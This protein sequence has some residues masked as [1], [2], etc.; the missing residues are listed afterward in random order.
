ML[1]VALVRFDSDEKSEKQ[2][3]K[4]ERAKE[5]AQSFL[6][7][8]MRQAAGSGARGPSRGDRAGRYRGGGGGQGRGSGGGGSGDDPLDPSFLNEL[9]DFLIYCRGAGSP[10]ELDGWLRRERSAVSFEM[11][12]RCSE[13]QMGQMRENSRFDDELLG[14]LE[15]LMPAPRATR[16]SLGGIQVKRSDAADCVTLAVNV[17]VGGAEDLTEDLNALI[18]AVSKDLRGNAFHE[19]QNLLSIAPGLKVEKLAEPE[20]E[21]RDHAPEDPLSSHSDDAEPADDASRW[22]R[23]ANKLLAWE[24]DFMLP[25]SK[26]NSVDE[27]P[28]WKWGRNRI[29]RCNGCAK[30]LQGHCFLYTEKLERAT[31]WYRDEQ[32]PHRSDGTIGASSSVDADA[33]FDKEVLLNCARDHWSS[34]FGP[35]QDLMEQECA[36]DVHFTRDALPSNIPT[37]LIDANTGRLNRLAYATAALLNDVRRDRQRTLPP[38]GTLPLQLSERVPPF[39]FDYRCNF[40]GTK[41][42]NYCLGCRVSGCKWYIGVSNDEPRR[43]RQH[44]GEELDGG[45]YIGA[46]YIGYLTRLNSSQVCPKPDAFGGWR[47]T[48]NPEKPEEAHSVC[49]RGSY[50]AVDEDANT[51]NIAFKHGLHHVRGGVHVL[52]ELSGAE[53]ITLQREYRAQCDLCILCGRSGHKAATCTQFRGQSVSEDAALMDFVRLRGDDPTFRADDRAQGVHADVARRVASGVCS[54]CHV[55]RLVAV[56]FPMTTEDMDDMRHDDQNE[57]QNGEI[58]A[59]QARETYEHLVRELYGRRVD[60]SMLRKLQCECLEHVV[61]LGRPDIVLTAPTSYGKTLMY[62]VAAVHEVVYGEGKAVIFLPFSALMSELAHT[63]AELTDDQYSPVYRKKGRVITHEADPRVVGTSLPYGGRLRIRL[64]K[65]QG[66]REIS[67]TIWRGVSGDPIMRQHLR[68]GVFRHADIILATPD[69]WMWPDSFRANGC[70]SF[71]SMLPPHALTA[72]GAL[73]PGQAEHAQAQTKREWLRKLGLIIAD[74]AHELQ[75]VL[76]GSMSELIRRMRTLRGLLPR[77]GE[78]GACERLRVMLVSATIERKEEFYRQLLRPDMQPGW[79]APPNEVKYVEA[80]AVVGAQTCRIVP[81]EFESEGEDDVD[82]VSAD[83]ASSA[84]DWL[85]EQGEQTR[86][87]LMLLLNRPIAPA[88]LVEIILRPDVLMGVPEASRDGSAAP[89]A[90]EASTLPCD[91]R[92][93]LIFIDSKVM[94]SQLVRDLSKPGFKKLWSDSVGVTVSTTPYHGD[95][96][97]RDRRLYEKNMGEFMP[98]RQLHFIVAT[99]AL[100]AG[101][102]CAFSVLLSLRSLKVLDSRS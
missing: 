72:E 4:A 9:D 26:R 16:L 21:W 84:V 54:A 3:R 15:D 63:L 90:A 1:P 91:L 32:A 88:D 27:L 6:E 96:A 20:L 5:R 86:Q 61:D 40:E 48:D 35:L 17:K 93:V 39:K 95:V 58:S 11:V 43:H 33:G 29:C 41:D 56:S 100:E 7:T 53:L 49:P 50:T 70:D 19:R 22:A 37:D 101:T 52:P 42:D 45:K 2:L 59:H 102:C 30:W 60:V 18:E 64:P 85:Q 69:K 51:R 78:G 25:Q 71:L 77:E 13:Q 76:G 38:Q 74:E 89:D 66:S 44:R 24:A 75:G 92:R 23:Y 98:K 8:K 12:L 94:C 73:A 14:V 81:E 57:G 46:Y 67:W 47:L 31:P 36:M 80:P 87:R 82:P 10:G 97:R 68:T 62:L 28:E 55:S 79:V 34:F 99:S 83:E 65:G